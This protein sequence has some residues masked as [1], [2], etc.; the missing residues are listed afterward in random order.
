MG[1]WLL[2][3][4]SLR[5]APLGGNWQHHAGPATRHL[6]QHQR[7]ELHTLQCHLLQHLRLLPLSLLFCHARPH[8]AFSLKRRLQS[9]ILDLQHH[10]LLLLLAHQGLLLPLMPH[11]FQFHPAVMRC[12]AASQ[13]LVLVLV[14]V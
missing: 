5:R 12:R 8:R 10:G 13:L 3:Q 6:A 4:C 1:W 2:I 7:L 9:H 11:L 14:L